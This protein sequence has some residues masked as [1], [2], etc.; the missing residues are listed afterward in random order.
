MLRRS[1]IESK[2]LISLE[3][4]STISCYLYLLLRVL[5]ANCRLK[6]ES[7]SGVASSLTVLLCYYNS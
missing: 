7:K 2:S 4:C 5:G 3:Q 6:S 1:Y